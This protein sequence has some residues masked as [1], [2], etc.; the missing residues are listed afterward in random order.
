MFVTPANREAILLMFNLGKFSFVCRW[1]TLDIPSLSSQSQHAKNTWS[2]VSVYTKLNYYS[3][4]VIILFFW[5]AKILCI[6]H[7]NQLLSTKKWHRK[8]S[9]IERRSVTS[10]YHSS[11][12]SGSQQWGSSL[13]N[14]NDDPWQQ[15][16]QKSN[17]F[18]LAKQQLCR[19]IM[20]FCT[21][22]SCCCKSA[23]WNFLMSHTRFVELVN[24][25]QKFLFHF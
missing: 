18:I 2:T 12:I 14:K 1:I 5:L 16:R 3:F 6:I 10:H 4:K 19:C 9:K 20:H 23:T 13:S 25:A 24:T 11:N 22:L 7:H 15:E 21:F 17:W 8:C